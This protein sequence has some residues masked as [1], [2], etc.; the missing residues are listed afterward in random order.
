M[1]AKFFKTFIFGKISFVSQTQKILHKQKFPALTVKTP[2]TEVWKHALSMNLKSRKW[3]SK[4]FAL[5]VSL[6]K[7]PFCLIWCFSR[8]S[9]IEKWHVAKIERWF[10]DL[11]LNRVIHFSIFAT[12]H[13]SIFDPPEK[14]QIKQ[15]GPFHRDTLNA[16]RFETHLRDFKFILKACFQTC[17]LDVFIV[18]AG[19]FCLCRIFC[20]W[21]TNE[22][23]AKMNVLKI[24]AFIVGI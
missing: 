22:I 20:I 12:C 24:L 16:K 21:L 3:V 23:F 14:H 7:G 15:N 9:K 6:W 10:L 5:S 13:F 1:Q 18:K 11:S 8:G 17:V 4:R 19:N 2:K